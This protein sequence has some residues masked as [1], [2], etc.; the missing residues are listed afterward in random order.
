MPD[1]TPKNPVV[2]LHGYSD[3]GNSFQTW[4]KKFEENN[5]DVK[6]IHI[7]QYISLSNEI[8]IEDIAEGLD[9]ALAEKLG[10]N[11]TFDAIVHST[12]MLVIRAWLAKY[13]SQGYYR[14][15]HLIGLAPATFGSPIAHK[16]RSFL[17]A[18]F[19]GNREWGPDFLEAGTRILD[20][21]ELGS[22]FSWDL[23]HKDLLGETTFYGS[24]SDTPFVFTFCGT[25]QFFQSSLINNFVGRITNRVGV[26]LDGT[27]GVVRWAGCELRTRKITIDFT[28]KQP[29]DKLSISPWKNSGIAHTVRVKDHNHGRIM[30]DPSS[31]LVE[32]VFQALKFTSEQ[33]INLWHQKALKTLS[34]NDSENAEW[35]QF[36]IRAIDDNDEPIPD[37]YIELA[38]SQNNQWKRIED[39]G[40]DVHVYAQ[41]KSLRCFHV[42]I[43]KTKNLQNLQIRI[44]AS[45]NSE[46]VR[47][48]GYASSVEDS[49]S[50]TDLELDIS[51]IL[52]Q[53][54]I[55][56]FYPFTTTLVEIRLKRQTRK[57][58]LQFMAFAESQF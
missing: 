19:K 6:I 7:C 55:K 41:D 24:D 50:V 40:V 34:P 39:F 28:K 51:P 1:A 21:L 53:K 33:D 27:D 56:F 20:A 14:L 49:D 25:Q 4:I 57:Q 43:T 2:M 10:N 11:R 5:Y 23:A 31:D 3:R 29:E 42:D 52:Q 35:Q 58:L 47:Y 44:V 32:S 12:G 36:I 38:T 16:G 18:L 26:P 30:G 54:D 15:Q 13:S 22:K 9:Q 48:S 45:S 37:Y 8:N 46:Y 17:G